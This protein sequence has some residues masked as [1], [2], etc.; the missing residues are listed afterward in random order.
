MTPALTSTTSYWVLVSNSVDTVDSKT[1]TVIVTVAPGDFYGD[2]KSDITVFRPSTGTWYVRGWSASATYVW[3]GGADIP[4][5]GDY[6]G[7]GITDIAV[8]RPSTGTWY[9]RYSATPTYAALVWG[10]LAISRCRAITTATALPTA[11]CFVLRPAPGISDT[12]PHRP[13]RP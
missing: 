8:F 2:G 13:T 12:R 9:I 5:P 11:R 10:A 1:A 6:D 4:V 3:G 7:D